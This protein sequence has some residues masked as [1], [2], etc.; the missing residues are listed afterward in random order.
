MTP[1]EEILRRY[2]TSEERLLS[3]IEKRYTCLSKIKRLLAQKIDPNKL[4]RYGNNNSLHHA[5]K[6]GK[7]SVLK[8]LVEAGGDPTNTNHTGQTALIIASRGTTRGHT[9]CVE[10]LLNHGCDVNAVDLEGR[11]PLRQAILASNLK[12][13]EL[14]LQFGSILS[15]NEHTKLNSEFASHLPVAITF[16]YSLRS[17]QVKRIPRIIRKLFSSNERIIS[18]IHS[19]MK[20]D[21]LYEY[22][23]DSSSLSSKSDSST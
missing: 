18:I 11:T 21:A 4:E 15:W 6:L 5:A 12:S 14:L 2:E 7:V 17:S 10:Y 3:E 23:E 1:A 16:A 22:Y 20:E 9:S 8:L 19:K 13:V